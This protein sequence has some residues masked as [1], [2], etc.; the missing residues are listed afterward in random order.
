MLSAKSVCM[1]CYI[2]WL[3]NFNF[4]SSFTTCTAVH[5]IAR[6]IIFWNDC[7]TRLKRASQH[8]GMESLKY[9]DVFLGILQD[10]G[11]IERFLEAIFSFLSRRTDYFLL[12][13][14]KDD[15]Y[16]FPPGMAEKMLI[17]V[18]CKI[19]VP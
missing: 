1:A 12:M 4:L 15:K 8:A 17:K 5:N 11:K 3:I 19:S 9:D 10:C 6:E 14:K 16:G 2:Y 13:H 7:C 18:R